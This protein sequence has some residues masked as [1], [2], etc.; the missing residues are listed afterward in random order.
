LRNHCYC[1]NAI[2]ITYAEF[3]CATLVIQ[4]AQHM[5]RIILSSVACLAAEYFPHYL[6]NGTILEKKKM[7]LNK[8]RVFFLLFSLEL[9]LEIF[10]F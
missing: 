1:G 7:L 6:I 4:Q 3:V 9:S 2:S 8:I 10:S 5:H